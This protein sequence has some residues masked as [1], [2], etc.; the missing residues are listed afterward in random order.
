M[1]YVPSI[2]REEYEAGKTVE[3]DFCHYIIKPDDNIDISKNDK[4]IQFK[5]TKKTNMVV[6]I[7]GG[8]DRYSATTS[9]I[10]N[11]DQAKEG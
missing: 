3:Y 5:V 8:S 1:K 9:I 11:N 7:Y 2:T 10:K 4:G 6:Y